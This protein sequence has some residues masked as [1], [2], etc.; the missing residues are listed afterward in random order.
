MEK[1]YKTPGNIILLHMCKLNEDQKMYGS[2]D[3]MAWRTKF[4]VVLGHFLPFDLPNKLKNWNFEKQWKK[5][6]WRYYH[7][8]LVYHKWWSYDV[9]ILRYGAQQTEF[10]IVL[11]YFLP[12]YPSNSW[13]NQNFE[14]MKK[15]P[16]DNIIL[17][18]LS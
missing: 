1:L 14:K 15:M 8:K 9:W 10:F 13:E 18:K 2:R 3:I 11:G 16:R 12:F 7:F 5:N 4:F 17:H 6:N